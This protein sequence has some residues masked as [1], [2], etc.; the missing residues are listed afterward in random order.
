M[1]TTDRICGCALKRT[2]MDHLADGD[3][4]ADHGGV[5]IDGGW[6]E[7]V[8]VQVGGADEATKANTGVLGQVLDCDR[9]GKGQG[10]DPAEAHEPAVVA[11]NKVEPPD[12]KLRFI[13]LGMVG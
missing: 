5:H 6:I 2:Y 12:S 3:N 8:G 11:V 1:L 4:V 10:E 13:E 9:D 7:E